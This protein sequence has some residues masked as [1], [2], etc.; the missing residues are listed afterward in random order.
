MLDGAFNVLKKIPGSV[1]SI[2]AG[3]RVRRWSQTAGVQIPALV[4]SCES[5]STSDPAKSI[6]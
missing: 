2:V 5:F 3:L 1:N 4:L 6:T